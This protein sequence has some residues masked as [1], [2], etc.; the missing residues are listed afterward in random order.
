MG[1]HIAGIR[2]RITIF[3]VIV[4]SLSL[5]LTLTAWQFSKHQMEAR[6]AQ[7]FEASRDRTLAAI[8]ERMVKYEDALWAGVAALDSHE[9]DISAD[10]WES[11]A[12]TL[13]IE[14][15]HRGINGIGVIYALPPDQLEAFEQ[16]QR[17]TRPDFGVFPAHPHQ[18]LM[19][20]TYIE[21]EAANAAAIGLDVAH[22]A[23]R[24]TAA[25]LSRDTGLAQISGPITLVQ[26]SGQTPGFL[27]YAPFYTGPEPSTRA[28]RQAQFAGAVYAPFV[29]HKLME[30]LLAKNLRNVRFSI[31]DGD[32][33]IYDEHGAQDPGT[34]PNPLFTQRIN[35]PI[36]G[37]IWE[38]DIRSDL[39]FRQQNL[40]VKPTAILVA[41]LM[42]E[43]LIIALL[44]AMARANTRA[45]T[46]ADRVTSD[47]RRKSSKL[48]EINQT[49][50]IKNEELEQYA[51]VTSHDLR[52]PIRGIGGLAEMIEE[53]LEPYF[54]SDAANP[55]V[56]E[57]LTRI[58]A[59]VARMH[60][61]TQGILEYS[62]ITP[63]SAQSHPV[64]LADMAL[65]LRHDFTLQKA[66]L[67]LTSDIDHITV[68]PV[69]FRRVIENLVGNAIKYH[70]RTKPLY[71]NIKIERSGTRCLVTVQD[72][73]PGIDPKFHERIFAVFQTLGPPDA[74]N[75]TGIGLAIVKKL[76][77]RVGGQISVTSLPGSGATFCFDWPLCKTTSQH[78]EKAA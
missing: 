9:G 54:A 73:G 37:R 69:H 1:E 77:A 76:V 28:Q 50:S 6:I 49:L 41:G 67:D 61:L 33:T 70:D 59:R 19:P 8:H 25:L 55:D 78:L 42:I 75:S 18:T 10:A 34:D 62:T 51:Y 46:Y 57:N 44:I 40:D 58:R 60:D 13:R 52:T 26:D 71:V 31:R 20:I 65:A 7:Q 35:M 66:E 32:E 47:L 45:V 53:D 2:G 64:A 16:R 24:R 38:I 3:H 56:A 29:V 43:A 22:E 4:V 5:F 15:R 11:F 63:D 12:R 30:G 27:F 68:E 48:V 23:N 21:P 39:T 17:R 72:N 14:E 36:F 74:A